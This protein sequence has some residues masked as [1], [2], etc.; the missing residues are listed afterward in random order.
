MEAFA[1]GLPAISTSHSGIPELVQDGISGFLV[2]ERD[3]AAL[4]EKLVLLILKP[5]LRR[6]MGRKGREQVEK[7]YNTA[8]LTDRLVKLYESLLA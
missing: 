7:H 8:K 2:P 4:K 1:I 3:V 6:Q 5:E